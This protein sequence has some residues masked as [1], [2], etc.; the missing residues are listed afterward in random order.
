MQNISINRCICF[1]LNQCEKKKSTK[2]IAVATQVSTREICHDFYLTTICSILCSKRFNHKQ[3]VYAVEQKFFI[4][5]SAAVR[6]C[7]LYRLCRLCF[8]YIIN[9]NFTFFSPKLQLNVSKTNIKG[10]SEVEC[11]LQ[12]VATVFYFRANHQRLGCTSNSAQHDR[13]GEYIV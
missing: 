1:R 6:Q 4:S 8:V 7:S 13:I 3:L 2:K 5:I 9:G 10:R 11:V 12:A